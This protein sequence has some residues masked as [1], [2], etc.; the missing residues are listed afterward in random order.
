MA[1]WGN[2]IRIIVQIISAYKKGNIPLTCF[3]QGSLFETPEIAHQLDRIKSLPII[4]GFAVLFGH[5]EGVISAV[6]VDWALFNRRFQCQDV[7]ADPA[8][9]R[10]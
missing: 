5:R 6:G 3:V 8:S 7:D 4:I 10:K 9:D 2:A 1:I